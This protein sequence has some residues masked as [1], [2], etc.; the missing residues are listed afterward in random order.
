MRSVFLHPGSGTWIQ[1]NE[2]RWQNIIHKVQ[3]LNI[4][5]PEAYC[6]ILKH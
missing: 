5:Q 3:P 6:H 4:D 1:W 2:L